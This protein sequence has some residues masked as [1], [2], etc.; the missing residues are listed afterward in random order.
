MKMGVVEARHHESVSVV[1]DFGIGAAQMLGQ[2]FK[3]A[4]PQNAVAPDGHGS[5][6]GLVVD[7]GKQGRGNEDSISGAGS[8]HGASPSEGERVG[9]PSDSQGRLG[10]SGAVY[11][12]K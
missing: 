6:R 3:R 4:G 1:D 12:L 8:C 7:T 10:F 5:G 11:A 9:W 2:D